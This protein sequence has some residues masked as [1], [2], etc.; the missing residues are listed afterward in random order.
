MDR[1]LGA[2]RMWFHR[3]EVPRRIWPEMLEKYPAVTLD[4]L[5][6]IE[7]TRKAA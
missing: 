1:T 6:E 4:R 2:V 5:R 7:A 3:G